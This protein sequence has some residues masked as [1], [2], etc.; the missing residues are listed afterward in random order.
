MTRNEVLPKVERLDP[1][2]LST[3][4]KALCIECMSPMKADEQ[5]FRCVS[6]GCVKFDRSADRWI[7]VELLTHDEVKAIA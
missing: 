2:R 4:G 5:G 3:L 6:R 1:P 7:S